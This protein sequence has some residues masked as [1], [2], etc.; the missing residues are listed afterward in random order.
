MGGGEKAIGVAKI[1]FNYLNVAA[2][3]NKTD[4]KTI[5][6]FT[7]AAIVASAAATAA[8]LSATLFGIMF[9]L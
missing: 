3:D 8:A 6:L 2:E 7:S 4:H 1:H 5:I 9:G